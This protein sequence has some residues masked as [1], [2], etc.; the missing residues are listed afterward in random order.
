MKTKIDALEAR[1]LAEVRQAWTPPEATLARLRADLDARLH[2]PG[3]PTLL[4]PTAS[5]GSIGGLKALLVTAV[6]SAGIA[7]AVGYWV[8]QAA[9]KDASEMPTSAPSPARGVSARPLEPGATAPAV[10]EMPKAAPTAPAEPPKRPNSATPRA[11]ELAPERE[12]SQVA[13]KDPLDA[14]VDLLRRVEHSLRQGNGRLAVA[15]LRELDETVPQGQLLQ[16]R[17]A[18]RIMANCMNSAP[19]A[20]ENAVQYLAQN[21]ASPF[22]ARVRALCRLEQVDTDDTGT[23]D[24]SRATGD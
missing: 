1:M 13:Y 7:F 3:S 11:R 17:T 14:E 15:L 24:G 16:E 6:T 9:P 23:N 8:G 21:G 22:A 12:A 18:S 2:D 10:P 4:E 19:R 5:L 20:Q